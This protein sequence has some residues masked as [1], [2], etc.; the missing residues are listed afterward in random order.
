M[1]WGEYRSSPLPPS[2]A[3]CDAKHSPLSTVTQTV[4]HSLDVGGAASACRA[5]QLHW[6]ALLRPEC[7]R[8]RTQRQCR[9]AIH[10]RFN[11]G[12][13]TTYAQTCLTF[14]PPSTHHH[15]HRLT[16]YPCHSH[17]SLLGLAGSCWFVLNSQA[18]RSLEGASWWH[19][20][21][22]R[23]LAAAQHGCGTRAPTG[24]Q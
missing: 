8:R 7:R 18:I 9:N 23:G 5:A 12:S 21:T 22:L 11:P 4:L 3:M 14:P 6:T 15:H 24:S 13:L 16:V 10:L 1:C 2:V 19:L 20:G 17:C